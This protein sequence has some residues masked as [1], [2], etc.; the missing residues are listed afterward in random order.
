MA[1]QSPPLARCR[2]GLWQGTGCPAT[3]ACFPASFAATSGPVQKA[4][5][6]ASEGNV[7]TSAVC[8]SMLASLAL[9]T[10]TGHPRGALKGVLSVAPCAGVC[11]RPAVHLGALR[12]RRHRE[13]H[14][15]VAAG[16]AGAGRGHRSPVSHHARWQ[17]CAG[18]RGARC[19]SCPAPCRATT[20]A[21][22]STSSPASPS[23]CTASWSRRTDVSGA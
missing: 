17:C 8:R 7:S 10:G 9:S 13:P 5:T 6:L 1:S 2:G 20:R 12:G 18:A 19:C 22:W 14:R 11:G 16:A 3:S 21:P 15:Q 23:R 4:P